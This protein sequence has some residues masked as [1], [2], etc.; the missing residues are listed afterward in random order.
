M[1]FQNNCTPQPIYGPYRQTLFL[2]LS[3]RDFTLSAG[4]NQ[5]ATNVTV[6][7]VNDVCSGTRDY[8]D[9]DFIWQTGVTFSTGDPGYNNP[10]LGSPVIFK[11]AESYSG[12]D[13]NNP[14]EDRTIV[15]AGFEFA[16]VLQSYNTVSGPDGLDLVTVNLSS[17]NTILNGV[18]F[19]VDR[20]SDEI[21]SDRDWETQNLPLL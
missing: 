9:S 2:G 4:L 12:I 15:E 11:I 17:P 5:Q 19:I 8:L 13:D 21:P 7:L 18:Q 14:E 16:G 1:A 3:V 10:P 6:N 20:L